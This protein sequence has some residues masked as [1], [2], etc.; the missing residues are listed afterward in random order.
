LI[1]VTTQTGSSNSYAVTGC[2][3]GYNGTTAASHLQNEW[4]WPQDTAGVAAA[5]PSSLCDLV[6]LLSYLSTNMGN[7]SVPGRK[8]RIWLYGW[9]HGAYM[10]QWVNQAGKSLLRSGMCNSEW[11]DTSW[12]VQGAFMI[13]TKADQG[14]VAMNSYVGPNQPSPYTVASPVDETTSGAALTGRN[15]TGVPSFSSATLTAAAYTINGL[16]TVGAN[17]AYAQAETYAPQFCQPGN[18]ASCATGIDSPIPQEWINVGDLDSDVGAVQQVNFA[19]TATG[20]KV[21]LVQWPG[22]D[23]TANFDTGPGCDAS[24]APCWDGPVVEDMLHFFSGATLAPARGTT[25]GLVASGLY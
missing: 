3:R 19:Q 16:P 11:T 21:T 7:G 9:S 5:L 13:S 24:G 2:V 8:D 23:H 15:A 17:S 22:I 12:T 20:I 6:T 18:Y 25:S 4:A 10:A 14:L 1:E